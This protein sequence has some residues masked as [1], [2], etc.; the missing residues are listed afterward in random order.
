MLF[1]DEIFFY[2]YDLLVN[3]LKAKFKNSRKRGNSPAVREKRD[4]KKKHVDEFPGH[5]PVVVRS[6]MDDEKSIHSMRIAQARGV[7]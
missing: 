5:A 1:I 2:L 6:A 4:A 3:R 7:G